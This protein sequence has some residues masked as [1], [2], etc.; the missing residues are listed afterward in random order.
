MD[1]SNSE[2]TH[3]SVCGC[4]RENVSKSA[5]IIVSFPTDGKMHLSWTELGICVWQTVTNVK[6]WRLILQFV[7]HVN[8]LKAT[9]FQ[10]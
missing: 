7:E 9:F 2:S 5:T 4:V 6:I 3:S 10:K 8:D 1:A